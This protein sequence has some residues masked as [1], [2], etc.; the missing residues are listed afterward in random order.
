MKW[1]FCFSKF[2]HLE[3]IYCNVVLYPERTPRTR[4][5]MKNEPITIRGTKYIPLK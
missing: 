1:T 2:M 3:I 4:F 5:N